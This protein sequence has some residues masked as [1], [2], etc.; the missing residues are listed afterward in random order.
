[1]QQAGKILRGA[2]RR[3]K[4]P[5]QPLDWL[6]GVWPLVV[7]KRLAERTRPLACAAG[8]LEIGVTSAAWRDQLAEMIVSLRAQI[9]RWWGGE[10]VRQVK[11]VAVPATLP[12]GKAPPESLAK[13][14]APAEPAPERTPFIRRGAQTRRTK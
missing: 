13:P 11:L 14:P 5:E 6:V 8:V 7:G 4:R 1:M 9:N 3:L 10:L 2:L 12:V